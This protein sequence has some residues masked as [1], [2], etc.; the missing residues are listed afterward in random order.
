MRINAPNQK[1]NILSSLL[2]AV[3]ILFSS[4]NTLV[5]LPIKA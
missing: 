5:I 3:Q 2:G 1:I 4:E